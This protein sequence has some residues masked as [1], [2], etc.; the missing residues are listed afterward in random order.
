[1]PNLQLPLDLPMKDNKFIDAQSIVPNHCPDHVSNVS[2]L[3]FYR[4]EQHPPRIRNR[5]NYISAHEKSALRVRPSGIGTFYFLEQSQD[6]NNGFFLLW[7]P[8]LARDRSNCLQS[9]PLK[10]TDWHDWIEASGLWDWTS[11]IPRLFSSLVTSSRK[12]SYSTRQQPFNRNQ[13]AWIMKLPMR[14]KPCTHLTR[15]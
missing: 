5:W 11:Y 1:M 6:D 15:L 3:E 8:L 12:T 13:K 2:L 14:T 10:N 9:P 4:L 7:V